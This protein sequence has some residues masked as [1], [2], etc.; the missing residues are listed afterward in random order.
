MHAHGRQLLAQPG[1]IG[2]SD[3]PHSERPGRLQVPLPVVDEHGVCRLRL[4][5]RQRHLVDPASRLQN[6]DPAGGEEGDED[7]AQ[8]EPL[9]SVLIQ[10]GRFVVDGHQAVAS[11][12]RQRAGQ[13]DGFRKR[14]A[15]GQHEGLECRRLERP[16]PMKHRAPQVL[17]QRH[18]A[19]LQHGDGLA[20][21]VFHFGH[22]EAEM[23]RGRGALFPIPAIAAE[24]PA[25][26]EEDVADRHRASSPGSSTRMAGRPRAR[27]ATRSPSAWAASSRP[28]PN[29]T[30]GIGSSST[31]C[32]VI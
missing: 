22:V 2:K 13:V 5:H 32:S 15:L 23:L 7:V 11:G 4:R 26:V 30:P 27:R 18:P 12:A 25:D 29:G 8:A 14:R 6:S 20:V 19:L 1:S 3:G 28:K 16:G 21:P 31:P 9:Q 24:N 10:F 17:I